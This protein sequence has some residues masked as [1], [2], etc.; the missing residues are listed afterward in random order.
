MVKLELSVSAKRLKNVAGAFKGTS[1]PFAVVTLIATNEDNKPHVLGKT[2]VV[3][4]NLDPQW[5][6][7][8]VFDY[9]LGQPVKL[10]INVFDEVR[11]SDNISMGSVTFDVDSILSARGGTRSKKIAGSRGVVTAVV[12]KSQGQGVL[13]FRFSALK[14]KNTEGFLRKSDPFYELVRRDDTAG[15]ATFNTVF[16]SE[17]VKD[18]LSPEWKPT[19]VEISQICGGNLDLPF[20]VKVFD[21]ESS[22]K[23]VLMGQFETTVNA[24]VSMTDGKTIALKVQGEETGTF[25]IQT[26]ELSIPPEAS[27]PH[28]GG[29]PVEQQM[30][31]LHLDQIVAPTMGRPTLVD[32]VSG[33]CQLQVTLAID[34]TGSNGDPRQPGTLHYLHQDG[35]LNDYEKA[36][37]AI[38]GILS[39]YDHDKKFPVLGFGAK[40]NS[41]IASHAFQCGSAPEAVGVRGVLDAYRSV[42]KFPG[43]VMSRP[44]VFN[45]VIKYAAHRA[46]QSLNVALQ[47]GGQ[48]YSILLLLTDGCVSD[49]EAT[50]ACLK[51]IGDKPISIVMVGVGNADFSGM[52]FLD[53][54]SYAPGRD[55]AQFVPFNDYSSSPSDLSSVTLNE[56]P[57]QLVNFFQGRGI[58][59]LSPPLVDLTT[60]EEDEEEPEIDLSLD[61]REN[62][63]FVSRGG[64]DFS[65]WG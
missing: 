25:V 9:K 49:V 50:A 43:F 23:H 24:L 15:G 64:Y 51:E 65:R 17:V 30:A 12:R 28:A 39:N 6:K 47:S 58:Q 32:Y 59:P 63:V 2:E 56:V 11:K 61:I 27:M 37:S 16:R 3:K 7:V 14:L 53:N 18:N 48:T 52:D 4:N 13:R 33:G 55:V 21:Y 46:E 26:A 42:F 8:F 60:V 38:L 44:T 22:G 31:K 54:M 45:D 36:I 34:F 19:A 40:L 1:D 29:P 41:D 5:A 62:E 35:Q 57:N 10:A 20:F